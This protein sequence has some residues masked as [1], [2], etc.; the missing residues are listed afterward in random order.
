VCSWRAREFRGG[1][2]EKMKRMWLGIEIFVTDLPP[3]AG[4]AEW[5]LC[6]VHCPGKFQNRERGIEFCRI[7]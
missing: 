5:N 3:L 1:S 7:L 6:C 2:D 4:Q